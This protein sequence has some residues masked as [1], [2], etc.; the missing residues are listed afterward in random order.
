MVKNGR[1]PE[2]SARTVSDAFES[3]FDGPRW[4]SVVTFQG[5]KAVAFHGTVISVF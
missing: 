1:L 3:R 2:Y 4:E 5:Q